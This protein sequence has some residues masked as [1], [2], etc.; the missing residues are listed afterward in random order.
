[1]DH[2]GVRFLEHPDLAVGHMHHVHQHD[3]RAE[4]ADVVHVL[5]WPVA[6]LHA[7]VGHLLGHGCEME[8]ERRAVVVGHSLRLEIESI[9]AA[10]E[11]DHVDAGLDEPAVVAV[12]VSLQEL[13]VFA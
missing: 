6:R 3:V 13:L 11:P 10:P 7:R 8:V 9:G 4:R 5:D 12:S 1:V 2:I